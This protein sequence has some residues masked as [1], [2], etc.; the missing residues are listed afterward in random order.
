[1]VKKMYGV[2]T[3]RYKLIMFAMILMN[4]NT[5]YSDVKNDTS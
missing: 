3:K 5:K 4:G 1:M 2:R